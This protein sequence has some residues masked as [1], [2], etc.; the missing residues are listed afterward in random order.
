MPLRAACSGLPIY[1]VVADVIVSRVVGRS[2]PR[3]SRA[4]GNPA[5]PPLR[6][7][8]ARGNPA[9]PPLRHS[10]ARG[11]PATPPLR[12]SRARGNPAGFAHGPASTRCGSVIPAH[13]GIQPP[14]LSVIPAHA[15][16]QPRLQPLLNSKLSPSFPR[17][18]ESSH[19]PQKDVS[20]AALGAIKS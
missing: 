8:R 4:R 14:H 6:H 17:T 20:N 2:S 18:R 16:I 5:T 15:G 19:A 3:H 13:A 7:S 9:I 10:R 12:H 11:N 1:L